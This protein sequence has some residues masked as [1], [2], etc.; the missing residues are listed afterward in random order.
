MS[1]VAMPKADQTDAVSP[2]TTINE[3]PRLRA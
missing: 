3:M 2:G 1:L